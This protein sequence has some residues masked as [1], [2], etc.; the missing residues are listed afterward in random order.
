MTMMTA[1]EIKATRETLGMNQRQ[2]GLL[3][4][5]RSETVCRWEH[6]RLVPDEYQIS[7]LE[8]LSRCASCLKANNTNVN[9]AKRFLKAKD[10]G[11]A[12]SILLRN[13]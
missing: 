4:N 12:L 2:F 9:M 6:N 3:V 7:I 1:T 8:A 13:V 5:A 11:R 10:S